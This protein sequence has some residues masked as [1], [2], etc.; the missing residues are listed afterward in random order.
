MWAPSGPNKTAHY[1]EVPIIGS[2]FFFSSDIYQYLSISA[3]RLL[4]M[5]FALFH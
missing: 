1:T 4:R 2:F 5:T 3:L